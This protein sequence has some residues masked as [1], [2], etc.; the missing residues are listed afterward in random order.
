MLV[1]VWSLFGHY[2][3]QKRLNFATSHETLRQ[4]NLYVAMDYNN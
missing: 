1:I 3:R 4:E 2:Y